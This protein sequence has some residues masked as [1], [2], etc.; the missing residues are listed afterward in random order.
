MVDTF[1]F[2]LFVWLVFLDVSNQNPTPSEDEIYWKKWYPGREESG[3]PEIQMQESIEL[4][5]CDIALSQFSS[6]QFLS[7][8]TAGAKYGKRQSDRS[9]LGQRPTSPVHSRWGDRTLYH[10]TATP[11]SSTLFGGTSQRRLW[12]EKWEDTPNVSKSIY[13]IRFSLRINPLRLILL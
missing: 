2:A 11:G 7:L 4:P 10:N 8:S 9:G 12:V 6:S 1:K 3:S 5:G 13:A